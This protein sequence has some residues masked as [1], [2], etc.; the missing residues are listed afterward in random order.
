MEWGY[1]NPHERLLLV[2]Q[3]RSWVLLSSVSSESNYWTSIIS[4]FSFPKLKINQFG[5]P[6]QD[7]ID[8]FIFGKINAIFIGQSELKDAYAPSEVGMKGTRSTVAK[9]AA[10]AI[11]FVTSARATLYSFSFHLV[12][13]LTWIKL[14][15]PSLRVVC[16]YPVIN[17]SPPSH[18]GQSLRS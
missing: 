1:Q 4:F 14:S 2:T 5:D 17:S 16:F 6:S 12:K 15:L 11:W 10:L 7:S 13:F 3:D 18:A 8:W 9:L